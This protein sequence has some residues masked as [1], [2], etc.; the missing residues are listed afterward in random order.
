M[1]KKFLY[2][3][4]PIS[5]D[6][7]DREEVSDLLCN[8]LH[9][10]EFQTWETTGKESDPEQIRE[11]L[12]SNAFD[13]VLVGGG[14]GTIKMVVQAIKGMGVPVGII[15]LGSANGLAADFGIHGISDA[16]HAIKNGIEKRV[17]LWDIN[18]ELCIH[19]SDFGFNAGLVR[20][21]SDQEGR[22][23][24]SYAKG[25][26]AQL[27]EIQS[28]RFR[29][30][31]QGDAREVTA[32]MLVIANA[33]KYGTGARINPFGD[34]SD[35]Q[36]EIIALNPEGID[37]IISLSLSLFKDNIEELDFVKSWSFNELEIENLDGADFQVDGEVM[38]QTDKVK[39]TKINE[40]IV[41]YALE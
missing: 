37:Q 38:P 24:L 18:G 16:C 10:V 17:D 12:N 31:E 7:D 6:G 21:S 22:G 5:G 14:D 29:L 15:P 27:Q 8:S 11:M 34:I 4:N 1:K 26:L 30:L 13:G 25:Y 3:V 35:G 23:M 40:P 19:L 9:D 2:V 20:K 41:F 33:A 32:K 36:F 28:Y 39:I